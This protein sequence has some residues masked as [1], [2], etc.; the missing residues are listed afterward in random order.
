MNRPIAHL[1][2]RLSKFLRRIHDAKVNAVAD[3]LDV[4]FGFH[5]NAGSLMPF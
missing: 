5:V 3:S 1:D 4:E 2:Q